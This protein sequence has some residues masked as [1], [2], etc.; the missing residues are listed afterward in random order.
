MNAQ[1]LVS[2]LEEAI[3]QRER[4]IW[5]KHGHDIDTWEHCELLREAV[6]QLKETDSYIFG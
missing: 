3:K 1:K 2:K 4:E 5:G 6:W